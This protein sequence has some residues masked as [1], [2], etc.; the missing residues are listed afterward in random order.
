[1]LFPAGRLATDARTEFP[2][3]DRQ[4]FPWPATYGVMPMSRRWTL[5]LALAAG[6]T[7]WVSPA[8]AQFELFVTD[9]T[10]IVRVDAT[11]AQSTFVSGLTAATGV[12]FDTAGNLFV[13]DNLAGVVRKF[14]ATGQD[15]GTFAFPGVGQSYGLAFDAP[16]NL[17]VTDG[18]SN[19]VRKYAP[20]GQ[21][22]GD[23]ITPGS[24][25]SGLV[26]ESSGNA[27]VTLLNGGEVWRMSPTGQDLGVFTTQTSTPY[28]IARDAAGNVYVT[29]LISGVVHK[30]SSTGTNLGAAT[31]GT[32][33]SADGIAFDPF[34]FLY[35][36][37]NVNN[38]VRRFSPTGQDL[39]VFASG[40]GVPIDIAMR[41][42]PE[43]GSLAAVGL[44]VVGALGRAGVG[45]RRRRAIQ[46][47]ETER[48]S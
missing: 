4:E 11:G 15:L 34:G 30:F 45:L 47:A 10:R 44:V 42:V 37:D 1:M 12:R 33:G 17:Y 25:P 40:I 36:G 9:Q 31:S 6:L 27:L 20:T 24:S 19:H 21:Q 35:V 7:G 32:L 38:N 48:A 46:R 16:G 39:G 13:A 28:K 41:A 2:I 5:F 43:P 26:F 29:E 18:G 8:R 14:S 3:R 22:L 23:F